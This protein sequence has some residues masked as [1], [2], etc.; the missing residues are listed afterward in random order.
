[1]SRNRLTLNYK[2]LPY[3]VEYLSIAD[4]EPKLKELGV[5]PS[6]YN[7][8]FQYTLPL[9]ADPSSDPNEKPTYVVESFNIALYLDQKYPEPK[10]P[11]V[12]PAST[13]ALQKIAITHIMNGA[14]NFGSVV[15]PCAVTR[16]G[17]PD[18]RG[19]EY[20]IRTR[21][22]IYGRDI[23]ELLPEADVN[24]AKAKEKW[25]ILG[26]QLDPGGQ[27]GPFV[28]GGQISLVDF[29][30]GGVIHWVRECEGGEMI[31][32]KDMCAWQGGRWETFWKEVQRLEALSPEVLA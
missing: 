15:L 3:R 19:C 7:P 31:R 16:P 32:W 22:V 12:I 26:D 25:E 23:R 30:I 27:D 4:I 17:F 1:M 13:R 11:A 6:S 28:M 5:P 20:Y 14:L 8:F 9:I 21:K 29:A 10:Y 24:W 2:R 18:E